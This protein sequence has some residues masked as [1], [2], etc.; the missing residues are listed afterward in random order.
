VHLPTWFGDFGVVVLD[1][2]V[3]FFDLAGGDD[4]PQ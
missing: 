4:L 3:V 1:D 2:L